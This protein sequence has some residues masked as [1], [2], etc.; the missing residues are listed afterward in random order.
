MKQVLAM[1]LAGGEGRRLYPLTMERA[2]PAVPF[3]GKY[4][5]IDFAINNFINSE[6]YKIKVLTQF[7]SDSLN[8]HIARTWPSSPLYNHYIDLVPAQMRTGAAW[9]QGTADAIYQNINLIYDEMPDLVCVF[10]GDHIYRMDIDQM[11]RFHRSCGA[12]LTIAGLPV[13]LA[14]ASAFG[15]MSI[16][17]EHRLVGWEEKPAA[18]TPMP[19]RPSHALVS[20]GNYIFN[21]EVLLRELSE[22]A[23]SMGSRHDFGHDIITHMV[24]RQRCVYVYDFTTNHVPGETPADVGYWRDVGDIDAYWQANMD[25]VSVT[26]AFNLYNDVWPIRTY[27]VQAPPA[28]F[29]FDLADRRG[30]ATDSIVSEGCIIS[31]GRLHRCVLSPYVRIN[32]FANVEDSILMEGVQVGRYSQIRRTIV[33]KGV[34]LPAGITVGYDAETDHRNGFFVSPGGVTVIPKGAIPPS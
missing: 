29:V 11:I 5:I 21:R 31:G 9:Y 8:R 34:Q 24:T 12:E 3:G 16:N 18:P 19:Q 17:A 33:D 27:A 28:K 30:V 23:S 4:R 2:K 15:V 6:I 10:G 7:K 22:D 20:M 13:P 1:I 14:D 25:L 32:S 26:P